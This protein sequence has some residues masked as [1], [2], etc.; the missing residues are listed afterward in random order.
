MEIVRLK[1]FSFRYPKEKVNAVDCMDLCIE[2]SEFVLVC[3]QSGCGKTTLLRNLKKE[4]T[5]H[6]TITG[7]VYYNGKLLA[8]LGAE[9]SASKIGFVRQNPENQI[10]MDTVRH[11]LAFGLENLGLPTPIIRR[12]V[13]ETA[14]FF[15]INSWFESNV[16]ELSGG[17][18]QLLNLAS[19]MAMQP[20]L[21]ILDEPTVQLDPIAAKEFLTMLARINQELGTT[22]ILSEHR[23]EDVLSLSDKVLLMNDGKKEFFGDAAQFIASI[24]LQPKHVFT[25][26]LPSAVRIAAALGEKKDVP[27]TVREGRAWLKVFVKDVSF[28]EA[29]I[30][31]TAKKESP[32]LQAKDVWFRYNESFVLRNFCAEV[33]A[34]QILS[35]VGGNASGKTTALSVM[36]GLLEP[37]RGSV[38]LDGKN[39]KKYKKN[40]IY[41]NNIA[42]LEQNPKTMFACDTVLGDLKEASDRLG[43]SCDD[44]LEQIIAQFSLKQLLHKHPYDLS[45]GEQQKAALAKLLLLEPRILLLDEPTKGIDVFAKDELASILK[46][47]CGMGNAVVIVTH[48][49]EFAAKHSSECAMIFNGEVMCRSDVREFF[50]G[51]MFYT[52]AANRISRDIVPHA[53]TPEDVIEACKEKQL[54]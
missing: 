37:I 13:A 10:V 54:Y 9:E 32:V 47:W 14:H 4:I 16:F 52:T 1:N 6:G 5:P 3:G 48:D 29:D 8:D 51:N 38:K 35:I 39:I 21:I 41:K 22:V 26:A 27:T 36:A 33:F 42:K 31:Q 28:D 17:Q 24:A 20:K 40:V 53:V 2:K 11:E 19:V 34:G 25:K 49:V 46:D 7:E 23:L 44:K 15:G 18:K 45:G 43:Q 30:K 50:A 12:R